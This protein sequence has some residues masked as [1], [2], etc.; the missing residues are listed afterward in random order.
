M[1]KSGWKKNKMMFDRTKRT[2]PTRFFQPRTLQCY[3]C[4]MP[5][6][7]LCGVSGCGTAMCGKHRY[8]KGG[9]SL[10]ASHQHAKLEQL[11]AV[12]TTRFKD[13]GVAVPHK[14]DE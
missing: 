3:K 7:Y 10:C 13:A 14:E 6:P 12:P 9:G 11:D 4:S 5:G 1:K 8:Q 2:R